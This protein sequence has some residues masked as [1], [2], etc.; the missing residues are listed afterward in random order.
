LQPPYLLLIDKCEQLN[1]QDG[2][3]LVYAFNFAG[4]V[5]LKLVCFIKNLTIEPVSQGV[6]VAPQ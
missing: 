3:F 4:F 1:A 6:L 2:D 5:K